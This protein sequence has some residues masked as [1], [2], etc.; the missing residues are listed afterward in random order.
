MPA[1][2]P[3]QA[4]VERAIRAADKLGLRPCA[5][6]LLPDGRVRLLFNEPEAV[7]SSSEAGEERRNS[8]DEA[9]GL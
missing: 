4:A 1:A 2:R 6:D 5:M 9:L 7:A 8:C 3:S